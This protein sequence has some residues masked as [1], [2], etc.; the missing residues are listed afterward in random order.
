[1]DF[2][3]LGFFIGVLGFG[4]YYGTSTRTR[5][6]FHPKALHSKPCLNP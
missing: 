6:G 1:M 4:L 5:K 2:A 3:A